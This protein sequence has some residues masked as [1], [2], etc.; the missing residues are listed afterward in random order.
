MLTSSPSFL[1]DDVAEKLLAKTSSG[2]VKPLGI[3]SSIQHR[4]GPLCLPTF[5]CAGAPPTSFQFLE[6]GQTSGPL[7]IVSVWGFIPSVSAETSSVGGQGL[8][9]LRGTPKFLAALLQAQD[10]IKGLSF[11]LLPGVCCHPWGC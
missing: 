9:H 7:A 2:S 6:S 3:C 1:R 10:R 11:I 5:L 4:E 8:E